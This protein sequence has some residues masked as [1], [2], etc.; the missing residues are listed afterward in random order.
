[1]RYIFV[2]LGHSFKL[3]VKLLRNFRSKTF[4]NSRLHIIFVF[5]NKRHDTFGDR[6]IRLTLWDQSRG[7]GN[8]VHYSES[9]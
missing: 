2:L 1:M 5:C 4:R 8:N 7:C 3:N 9:L 6:N